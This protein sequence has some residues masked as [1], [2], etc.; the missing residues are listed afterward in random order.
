MEITET[1]KNEIKQVIIK[2]A[3]EILDSGGD[4]SDLYSIQ[5]FIG[6][7]DCNEDG[8]EFPGPPDVFLNIKD[9]RNF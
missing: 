2:I 7:I 3:K 4:P 6:S 1:Q 9:I 8:L 5:D